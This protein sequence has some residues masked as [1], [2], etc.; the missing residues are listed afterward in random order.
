MHLGV[1]V[2][3]GMTKWLL[4]EAID[5]AIESHR[6]GEPANT[7]QLRMIHEYHGVLPRAV[8]RGKANKVIEFLEDHY[9]PCPFCGIEVCATD[10]ECC[11]CG[12]SLR[13][14]RIPI[15]L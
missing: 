15:K 7:E 11:A 8:T 5:E 1:V 9:L 13:R 10:K 6:S 14:M 3:D 12:K 4:S 2:R